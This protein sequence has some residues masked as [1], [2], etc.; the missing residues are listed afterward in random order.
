[1]KSIIHADLRNRHYCKWIQFLR[2]SEGWSREQIQEYQL[3]ELRRIVRY[4]YEN[5]RAYRTL[6]DSVGMTPE[7]IQTIG[8]FGR[9]PFVEKEMIRDNL[10]EFSVSVRGRSYITTGGS[11]GIPF[12]FY[13]TKVA[14]ARELASKAYQYYRVGWKEG[15]R[16]LVLRGLPIPSKNHMKY[17]PRFNELRCSSYHLVPDWME[18]Y[19]QRAF[20]FKPDWLKCYPSSGYIFAR[21]LKETGRPFPPIKGIFCAHSV[22]YNLFVTCDF[23]N[24]FADLRP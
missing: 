3:A 20:D 6:Y 1:M 18:I 7:A 19:R 22:G 2:E 10:E 16:Q 4:A 11:T 23:D 13:R 5:T 17:Y 15:D 14:F 9:L 21:F 24:T 8:D 12:G